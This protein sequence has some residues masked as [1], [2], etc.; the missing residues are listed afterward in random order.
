MVDS[1][2]RKILIAC[3]TY[4]FNVQ[5]MLY[6]DREIRRL[7]A[8]AAML[9]ALAA[10]GGGGGENGQPLGGNV[11][12]GPTLASIQANIFTPTCAYSS[13]CHQGAGAQQGLQLDDGFSRGNL[14]NVVSPQDATAI[15]VR[16]GDP[17]A[18]F[19]IH[20]L[21]GMQPGGAPIVGARMPADMN[22]LQQSTVNVIREWILNGAQP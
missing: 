12:L 21:E 17:D 11:P 5:G 16:P 6:P 22:Y 9:L 3:V 19:L 20:K 18:S 13:G 4:N 8:I 2:A 10:C 15:R 7:I 1:A 14:V